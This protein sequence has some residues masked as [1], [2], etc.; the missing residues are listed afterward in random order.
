MTVIPKILTMYLRTHCATFSVKWD[1]QSLCT[2]TTKTTAKPSPHCYYFK[3]KQ[4]RRMNMYNINALSSPMALTFYLLYLL[5]S[6]GYLWNNR[7]IF[8]GNNFILFSPFLAYFLYISHGFLY[9]S[10]GFL[11]ISYRSHLPWTLDIYE[12]I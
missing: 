12:L 1:L 8:P 3:I 9:I 4:N 7:A 2:S 10:F 11:Y 6:Q 5:Q